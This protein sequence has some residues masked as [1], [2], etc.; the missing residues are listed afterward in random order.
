MGS[1]LPRSPGIQIVAHRLG[2]HA[3]RLFT[4][5][6]Q[7]SCA[8]VISGSTKVLAREETMLVQACPHGPR[9]AASRPPPTDPNR[10][11]SASAPSSRRAV[12][13]RGR[14]AAAQAAR[15][16]G[17]GR[18]RLRRWESA[19]W[20]RVGTGWSTGSGAATRHAARARAIPRCRA[21][22]PHRHSRIGSARQGVESRERLG[23]HC[24]AV[25][26]TLAWLNRCAA[27]AS[28][29]SNARISSRRSGPGAV[30]TAAAISCT[31]RLVRHS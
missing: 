30:H 31:G 9:P 2:E 23:R 25:E 14:H 15:V 17:C 13:G 12:A 4:T 16:S 6:V 26:R 21:A 18:N 5:L 27:Y 11:R 8:A 10:P 1:T 20:P 28:A 29:L 24:G 3:D 7:L 19:S 22:L